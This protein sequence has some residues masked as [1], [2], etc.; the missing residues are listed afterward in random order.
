[1]LQQHHAGEEPFGSGAF[2]GEFRGHLRPALPLRADQRVVRQQR[3]V[4]HDFVEVLVT[5]EIR[6]R[7]YFDARKRQVDQELC[8][9]QL[10]LVG[11]FA[12]AKQRYHVLRFVRP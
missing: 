2:V 1:M 5:G 12:G 7:A 3:V 6:D 9:T 11:A 10:A 4:E 8:Q